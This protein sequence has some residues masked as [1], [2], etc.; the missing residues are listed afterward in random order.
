MTEREARAGGALP[1]ALHPGAEVAAAMSGFLKEFKGFQTEMKSALQ[2]QEERLTMLNAKTMSYGRPALS[3]RA[4]VEA[5]HQKA[6]NAYLRSGDDDGLRG[7]TL[8]GKAMS[9]AVAADGGYLVDPQTSERIQSLLLSTSSLRSIANVVQ[10]EATSFDVIVDRSEVG[11]GW[12][13]EAAAQAANFVCGANRSDAHLTGIGVHQT[14]QIETAGGG[15][16]RR[17]DKGTN[18]PRGFVRLILHRTHET[19]HIVRIALHLPR[20]VGL[21]NDAQTVTGA[22]ILQAPGGVA[23]AQVHR[24]RR[25]ERRRPA[26]AQTRLKQ[27]PRRIAKT[28]NDCGLAR[29]HL[30]QARRRNGKRHQQQRP[31]HAPPRERP[32]LFRR[33]VMMVMMPMMMV[34][35]AVAVI[36]AAVVMICAC[37]LAM[38]KYGDCIGTP[39]L[40]AFTSN[41]VFAIPA[42][43]FRYRSAAQAQTSRTDI[44][45]RLSKC[46]GAHSS[47]YRQAALAPSGM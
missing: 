43:A 6:F 19:L 37:L 29:A 40:G 9:T 10:V 1:A 11:S 38:A 3:A 45:S 20:H 31:A 46:G 32:R 14:R 28:G 44:S 24:D 36:V 5:P 4:E 16:Q 41:P 17:A 7:L 13:T 22:D 21:H 39:V 33:S 25:F 30:H 12:A 23:Q 8:E 26:P 47:A 34:M 42:C 35:P 18:L 2:Q 27:H 15:F